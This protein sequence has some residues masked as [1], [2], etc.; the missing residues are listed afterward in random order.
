[1]PN[2][3][4]PRMKPGCGY[5]SAAQS[6][7]AEDFLVVDAK[8]SRNLRAPLH[9]H[10]HAYFEFAVN[11]FFEDQY[12]HSTLT[13][14]KGAVGFDPG[15]APHRTFAHGAH[16]LRIEVAP[17][18]LDPIRHE[19]GIL[20]EPAMLTDPALASI[21]R[22]L[23][24]EVQSAQSASSVGTSLIVQALLLELVGYAARGAVS[25][26]K[27]RVAPPWLQRVQDRLDAEFACAPSLTELSR[28]AGVHRVHLARTFRAFYGSS[29]GEYL[30]A[31]QIDCALR[32]LMET[33]C[34]LSAVALSAGFADQSHFSN[35]FR[36]AMRTTPSLFRSRF[37]SARRAPSSAT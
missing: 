6:Y 9:A 5:Q 30:R 37:R 20:N 24:V 10:E 21:C 23:Y 2:E 27:Q 15:D 12:R 22:R 31:R 14:N 7:R 29:V 36:K 33:D 18:F 8:L 32:L 3:N 35:V 25:K 26:P 13:Y 16:I 28:D 1:M 19:Y 11:G 17:T 34:A 4:V